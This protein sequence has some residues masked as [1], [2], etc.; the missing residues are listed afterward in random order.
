M[1]KVQRTESRRDQVQASSHPPSVES[2]NAEF[3][4]QW[5]VTAY[6]KYCQ[7]GMFTW[8]LVSEVFIGFP[9]HKHKVSMWLTLVLRLQ[10]L[11]RSK[12][13]SVSQVPTISHI[14]GI[15]YLQWH[16]ALGLQRHSFQAGHFLGEGQGPVLSL[17][18]ARFEHRRPVQLTFCCTATKYEEMF[19]ENLHIHQ[20]DLFK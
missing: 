13:Y 11:Q 10:S 9:S 20:K 1:Q 12:W 17:D 4:Q 14:V 18:C 3:S 2:D 6:I 5:C 16:K 15:N 7:P 19:E 8:A